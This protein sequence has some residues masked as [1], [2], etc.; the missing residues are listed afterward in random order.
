MRLL[1]SGDVELNPGPLTDN[2][3]EKSNMFVC[4][5]NLQGCNNFKKKKR[6]FN[7][8]NKLPFANSCIINLQET[9]WG[10]DSDI[11]YH[12]RKGHVISN[13]TTNS[14][15]VAI[16]YN[17]SYFDDII[18]TYS[19]VDGRICSVTAAKDSE[20]YYYIN[21]YAPNDHYQ[22]INFFEA[23]EEQINQTNTKYPNCNVIIA[24]DFNLVF[25]ISVDSIGRIQTKQ[26][27]KVVQNINE[28]NKTHNLID[29]YRYTN[30][31]GGFTW[32]KNNPHYLRSRL[33]H[34]F[35]S[36][37]LLQHLVSSSLTFELME[38]DHCFLFSEYSI[39]EMKFG[40][41]IIR[42]NAELLE[43]PDVKERVL[44]KITEAHE[45]VKATWNPH[46]ILDHHKYILRKALLDEGR[47]KKIEEK[48]IIENTKQE[49]DML[50]KELDR[51]LLLAQEGNIDLTCEIENLR[52]SID[53]AEEPLKEIKEKEAKRLIFRSKA[54]WSEEGEK[55][56]SGRRGCK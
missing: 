38:S 13:G 54:R 52:S 3:V 22:A 50:K 33:D 47:K 30:K 12:W 32:G 44:G 1:L 56:N 42:A 6:V 55:L 35:T 37:N 45:S 11:N 36:E 49:I 8:L 46:L 53:I 9:H 48:S 20:I 28:M 4:T 26:E 19:D 51:I 27:K 2:I 39:N 24:G 10:N 41:G 14:R 21:V 34:I 40:P 23:V 29:V 16:L 31:Y 15:G 5:Y 7:L 43:D 18:E 25:D 17:K